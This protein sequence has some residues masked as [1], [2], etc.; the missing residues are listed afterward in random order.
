MPNFVL[1]SDSEWNILLYFI[2]KLTVLNY[3]VG[4]IK[5]RVIGS[6]KLFQSSYSI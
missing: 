4:S 3:N 1:Y 5:Y 2:L 6:I